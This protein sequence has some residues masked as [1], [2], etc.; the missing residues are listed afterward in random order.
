MASIEPIIQGRGVRIHAHTA[1]P[2][3]QTSSALTTGSTFKDLSNSG[4]GLG[5]PDRL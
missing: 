2:A 5:N 3:T 1:P 4:S